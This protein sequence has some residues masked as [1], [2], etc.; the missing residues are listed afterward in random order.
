[1]LQPRKFHQQNYSKQ[2]PL[3][4]CGTY[5][6]G[7]SSLTPELE[8]KMLLAGMTYVSL[9]VNKYTMSMYIHYMHNNNTSNL[10]GVFLPRN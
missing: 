8:K 2:V 3:S 6:N 1:M 4:M 5:E 9:A 7:I 10:Y